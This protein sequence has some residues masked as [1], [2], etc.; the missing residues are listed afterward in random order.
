MR[1]Q[2][3]ITPR[4]AAVLQSLGL[5]ADT[6]FTHPQIRVWRTLEDRQNAILDATLDDARRLRLHIKRYPAMRAFKSPAEL[7]ARGLGL[8]ETRG[9]PAA[10]LVGWGN[11]PDRRSF[12]ILEDLSNHHAADK[13]LQRGFD[14]ERLLDPAAGLAAR[15]HNAGLHHRDLYL[16]H[17]FAR[18]DAADLDLRLIDAARVRPLPFFFTSR[19][20][21]KDLAQFWYST[22]HHCDIRDEQRRDWLQRYC[23]QRP[24]I[25]SASLE[26]RILRK[27]HRMARHDR[28]LRQ[29]QPHRNV[30]IPED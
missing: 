26:G 29:Q 13:L 8:L 14:F 15:L 6:V 27:V 17:F 9:I 28:L 22:L 16:N 11:L 3:H 30:P 23:R 18:P 21:V 12:V 24:G 4:Y 1:P 2:V 19:W 10:P 5:D 20:I 25:D 7:E